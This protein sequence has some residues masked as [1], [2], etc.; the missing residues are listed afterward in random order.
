M[1]PL[2][3]ACGLIEWV[4]HTVGLRYCCQSVYR[5]AGRFDRSTNPTIKAMYDS[6]QASSKPFESSIQGSKH[7]VPCIPIIDHEI[8]HTH[9]KGWQLH[10]FEKGNLG[11]FN[12]IVI[13]DR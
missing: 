11:Q 6:Y 13:G 7:G 3:E 5:A 12:L 9:N 4:S 10:P 8:T 2:T 1:T